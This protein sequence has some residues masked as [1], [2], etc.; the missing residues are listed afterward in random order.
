[1]GALSLLIDVDNA[2]TLSLMRHR[3]KSQITSMS[4]VFKSLLFMPILNKCF[5]A[6]HTFV[7][8]GDTV[9]CALPSLYP[10]EALG[11]W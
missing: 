4:Q 6:K 8:K 7:Q 9:I 1:M 2:I 11:T 10:S 3:I 5:E